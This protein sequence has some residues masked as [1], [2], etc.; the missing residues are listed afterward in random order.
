MKFFG[1]VDEAVEI[2]GRGRE[3]GRKRERERWEKKEEEDWKFVGELFNCTIV[4]VF[5][6]FLNKNLPLLI[7]TSIF[8]SLF[9]HAYFQEGG[10]GGGG[11]GCVKWRKRF[12]F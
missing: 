2:A 8:L 11:G 5:N 12:S 6:F 1:G 9:I 10:R 7:L 4:F 3:G